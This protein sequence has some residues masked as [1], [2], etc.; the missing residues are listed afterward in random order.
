MGIENHI[1]RVKVSHPKRYLF[2]YYIIILKVLE[3]AKVNK[4]D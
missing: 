3:I 2:K 4:L 1:Y